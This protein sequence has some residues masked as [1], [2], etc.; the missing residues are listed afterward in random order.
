MASGSSRRSL[1]EVVPERLSIAFPR[2]PSLGA[3]TQE[4]LESLQV[5]WDAKQSLGKRIGFFPRVSAVRFVSYMIW[6]TAFGCLLAIVAT[7]LYFLDFKLIALI[8]LL[9]L[10]LV[11]G[12]FVLA[13]DL[14]IAYK[15]VHSQK[16]AWICV[17][18]TV[19]MILGGLISQNL[20]TFLLLS[21]HSLMY[22]IIVSRDGFPVAYKR[23]TLWFHVY[24]ILMQLTIYFAIQFT[25]FDLNEIKLELPEGFTYDFAQLLASG[26]L[27][28]IGLSINQLISESYY[29]AK[30]CVILNRRV[31]I[32]DDDFDVNLNNGMISS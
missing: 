21:L 25:L 6:A 1:L 18:D 22:P 13:M 26:I 8:I 4:V 3:D 5:R 14:S 2:R 30:V 20:A 19:N 29:G 17:I 7:V 10:V 16:F 24:M 23:K 32:A 9:A 27:V 31:D 12:S 28:L 11:G 15:N